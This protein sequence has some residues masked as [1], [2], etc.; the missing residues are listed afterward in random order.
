MSLE[1]YARLL[2][3]LTG[4]KN[5]AELDNAA[6]DALAHPPKYYVRK[7][8]LLVHENKMEEDRKDKINAEVQKEEV[9]S[10]PFATF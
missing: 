5:V 1:N 7:E 2:W 10:C 6:C 9:N 3:R 8:S 4:C